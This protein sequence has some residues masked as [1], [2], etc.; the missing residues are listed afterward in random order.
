MRRQTVGR[1]LSACA[2]IALAAGLFNISDALAS[3]FGQGNFNDSGE[4]GTSG[5]NGY[6][7]APAIL[8]T[9]GGPVTITYAFTVHRFTGPGHVPYTQ[10]IDLDL[11]LRVRHILAIEGVKDPGLAAGD[12][13]LPAAAGHPAW[14]E[15]FLNAHAPQL[16]SSVITTTVVPSH[17]FGV[18]FPALPA[19]T[20]NAEAAKQSKDLSFQVTIPRCGY[21]EIETGSFVANTSPGGGTQ[22]SPG[23]ATSCSCPP[24]HS[25]GGG[26]TK[27]GGDYFTVLTRSFVRAVSSAC[28]TP[29]PTPTATPAPVIKST[30]TP[31]A[32]PTGGVG[33]IVATPTPTGSVLAVAT[34][35]PKVTGAV[36]PTPATGLGMDVHY[37]WGFVLLGLG[38]VLAAL[39][40]GVR[41]GEL[42]PFRF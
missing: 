19:K 4:V 26:G 38:G 8:D 27:G 35:L 7:P 42:G 28:S 29:T 14:D 25:S 23:P 5:A 24:T 6:S 18:H 33:G 10:A 39:A 21:F 12:P 15:A 30:P 17:D 31:I 13:G 20:T 16:D 2:G 22:R 32:T 9:S 37:Y 40:T 41:K 3:G 36:A 11:S 1:L 34:S